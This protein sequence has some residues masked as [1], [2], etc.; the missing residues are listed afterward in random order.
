MLIELDAAPVPNPSPPRARRPVRYWVAAVVALVLALVGGAAG[1]DRAAEV[2]EVMTVEG[3]GTVT[4]LLTSEAL[5]LV[6]TDGRIEAR[7]LCDKCPE[8]TSRAAAAGQRLTV[9]EGDTLILDGNETGEVYFLDARTGALRWRLSEALA[10]DPLGSLVA[11]WNF[12]K[13]VLQMRDLRTGRTLWSRPAYNYTADQAYAVI[14]DEAGGATVYDAA[15]GEERTPRHDLGLPDPAARLV[16]E[17]LI[18]LGGSYVAAYRRDGLSREWITPVPATYGVVPCDGLL[19]A[20]GGEGL[21]VLDPAGGKI[22]WAGRTWQGLGAGDVL[23]E[24]GGR[25]AVVDFAT[26][27]VEREL[28][29]SAPVGD[30]QLFPEPG[31]TSVIALADGRVRGTLPLVLPGACSAAGRYLACETPDVTYTVWRLPG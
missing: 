8:W 27:R 19:C 13:H 24:E 10:V 31:R 12:E 28:G 5:Y 1:P 3:Q 20:F 2:T 16:G 30:W 11:A 25:T 17:R 21:T 22:R 14:L 4:S 23:M 7:P 26:G 15:S 18:L 29:R 6:R 9:A